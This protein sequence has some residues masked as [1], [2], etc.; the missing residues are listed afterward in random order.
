MLGSVGGEC[1]CTERKVSLPRYYIE[2]SQKVASKTAQNYLKMWMICQNDLSAA[3]CG[4]WGENNISLKNVI[5][6]FRTSLT[7]VT[8]SRA[9]AASDY[10]FICLP[11]TDLWRD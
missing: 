8:L 4:F 3:G 6:I 1:R 10:S 2:L 11:E 5:F 9:E 7:A